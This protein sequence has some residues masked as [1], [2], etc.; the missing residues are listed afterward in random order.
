MDRYFC[1]KCKDG[2]GL[3]HYLDI[4]GSK[5]E[6][7]VQVNAYHH[8]HGGDNQQWKWHDEKIVSLI[9]SPL[10]SLA[11]KEI[12]DGSHII[13]RCGNNEND[14]NTFYNKWMFENG[15]IKLQADVNFFI[16]LSDENIV[17]QNDE[18]NITKWE[19][20]FIEC[21]AKP[22][23]S[24][25]LNY[26]PIPKLDNY[27]SWTLQNT[28][29][30]QRSANTTYF[31]IL[32][33][34]PGGYSGIQQIDENHRVVIFSMWNDCQHNVKVLEYGEGVAVTAFGG[35]GTG[36]KAMKDVD[37]ENNQKV[38][39]RVSGKMHNDESGTFWRCSGWYS[40]ENSDWVLMASYE[41][42]GE[43]PPFN[44]HLYAF[45]EDWDRSL[46]CEGHCLVRSAEFS[47]AKLITSNNETFNFN[48]AVFTKQR[49]GA[50]KFALEKAFGGVKATCFVLS[51]GGNTKTA[52][53]RSLQLDK[54][55]QC[56]NNHLTNL[57]L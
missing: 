42:S 10:Y 55:E 37:W 47:D 28:V 26:R 27:N 57:E 33:W 16:G 2:N 1:F 44:R 4:P 32:G 23:T 19:T 41:R 21:L 48:K 51:T 9:L 6:E 54:Y 52:I 25:H 8:L 24:C 56:T 11:V 30:V 38:T 45:I 7:G 20:E 43:N 36:M 5:C 13:L 50:D 31:C 29:C 14:G 40:I 53:Q 12:K 39:F 18:N 35:E 46:N 22:A 17:L 49:H 34:G 15:V 3:L